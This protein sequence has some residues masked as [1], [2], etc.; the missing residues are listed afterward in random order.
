MRVTVLLLP[1]LSVLLPGCSCLKIGFIG[2]TSDKSS[3][4]LAYKLM[5]EDGVDLVMQNG[6][7]DYTNNPGNWE[8][9]LNSHWFGHGKEHV[10]MTSGNHDTKKW[11]GPFGYQ[12]MLYNKMTKEL[13]E[14]CTGRN[15]NLKTDYGLWMSCRFRG[16]HMVM[17]GWDEFSPSWPRN[18]YENSRTTK[19]AADFI[20]K[21]FAGSTEPWRVCMWH[22][23][24]GT[25]QAGHRYPK[26]YGLSRAFDA[27]RRNGAFIVAGHNHLYSRTKL[28][29]SFSSKRV[30]PNSFPNK[31][32]L[33]CGESMFVVSG[34]GGWNRALD[35]DGP[36]AR[37]SWIQKRY[38]QSVGRE[39]VGVFVCDLPES[40][41]GGRCRYLV[42]RHATE[43]DSFAISNT[44]GRTPTAPTPLPTPEP[45]AEPT[46]APKTTAPDT[47]APATPHPDTIA[48][49]T[50]APA[51]PAPV[52][53]ETPVPTQAPR[54][55]A[56]DTA[57][58]DT[59]HPATPHPDTSVPDTA[60]PTTPHP[61]TST[62]DTSAPATPHPDTTVPDT[63]APATPAPDTTVPNTP[64]PTATTP[65][66]VTQAPPPRCPRRVPL[67]DNCVRSPKCCAPPAGCYYQNKWYAQ[68]LDLKRFP[69]TNHWNGPRIG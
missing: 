53:P 18:W 39:T 30:S 60:A 14:A 7:F 26:V 5:R 68:C 58:P 34:L 31:V 69:G 51:T 54:T 23:P 64:E 20:D 36:S 50:P 63:S 35:R 25:Y 38:T 41:E 40:G 21:S 15:N 42:G 49:R 12:S 9:F 27:C 56:P 3:A 8:R 52:V 61:D 28:L 59:P 43:H 57:A 37:R 47:A 17:I 2:D 45:T 13:R 48:P 66:V 1:L 67:W 33:S 46:L 24:E 32:E 44:C 4:G 62:P 19:P 55:P 22:R 29:S 10:L 65:P 6:D 11:G 16:V